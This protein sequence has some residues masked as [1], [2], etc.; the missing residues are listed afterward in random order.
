MIFWDLNYSL[1]CSP[2]GC[3]AYPDTPSPGIYDVK[4]FG[5]GQKTELFRVLNL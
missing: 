3:Q 4:L 1:G 2:L 5:V